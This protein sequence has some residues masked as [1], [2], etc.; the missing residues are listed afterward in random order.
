[1]LL[2]AKQKHNNTW[3]IKTSCRRVKDYNALIEADYV[4]LESQAFIERFITKTTLFKSANL[5]AIK[6][7]QEIEYLHEAGNIA[8]QRH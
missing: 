6:T 1:M 7:E 3:F 4:T 8:L 2:A 5:R